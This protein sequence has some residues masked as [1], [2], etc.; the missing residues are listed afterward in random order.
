MRLPIDLISFGWFV[1]SSP[2]LISTHIQIDSTRMLLQSH[3]QWLRARAK[4]AKGTRWMSTLDSEPPRLLIIAGYD[5]RKRFGLFGITALINQPG[6]MHPRLTLY[7]SGYGMS[8]I[9]G[10]TDVNTWFGCFN[11]H[12]HPGKV[13]SSGGSS[14][15]CLATG[16]TKR[17]Y[18]L[19]SIRFHKQLQSNQCGND[20]PKFWFDFWIE[21]QNWRVFLKAFVSTMVSVHSP[22]TFL[23]RMPVFP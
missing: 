4:D 2:S 5:F 8:E 16:H 6:F 11:P 15:G 12:Q 19:G 10:G 7:C 21:L 1:S 9:L 13:F 20:I 3:F 14:K 22:V 18:F 17:S 23:F